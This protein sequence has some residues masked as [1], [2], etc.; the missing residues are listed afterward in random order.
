M[1]LDLTKKKKLYTKFLEE[2]G[3]NFHRDILNDKYDMYIYFLYRIKHKINDYYLQRVRKVYIFFFLPF[4]I[5]KIVNLLILFINIRTTLVSKTMAHAVIMEIIKRTRFNVYDICLFLLAWLL[6]LIV[7]SVFCFNCLIVL[8]NMVNN[9]ITAWY[10]L[11]D[12]SF[13]RQRFINC[14]NITDIFLLSI[15][16]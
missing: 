11:F 15:Q 13:A 5:V 14:I 1:W 7:S 10:I 2:F 12:F 6:K 3:T 4:S 16:A 9:K 8:H